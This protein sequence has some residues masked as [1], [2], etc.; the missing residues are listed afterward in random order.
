[1]FFFS[2]DCPSGTEV[3]DNKNDCI[4]C[5]IGF[6]RDKA[7]SL[8]CLQ[9]PDGNSTLSEGSTSVMACNFGKN[10][11]LCTWWLMMLKELGIMNN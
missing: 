7:E 9:C 5:R 11:N 8:T 6:Y 1:M 4:K 2:G 10:K 3:A